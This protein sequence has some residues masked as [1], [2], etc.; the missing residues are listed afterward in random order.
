MNCFDHR[1]YLL[2]YCRDKCAWGVLIYAYLLFNKNT[3]KG[4]GVCI[5]TLFTMIEGHVPSLFNFDKMW[6]DSLNLVFSSI[7][8]TYVK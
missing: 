6:K 4:N 3:I 1:A 8:Q 7:C 5:F 2:A